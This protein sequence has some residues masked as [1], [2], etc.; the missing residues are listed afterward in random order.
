M[1]F[2]FFV[3]RVLGISYLKYKPKQLKYGFVLFWA[4]RQEQEAEKRASDA[5]IVEEKTKKRTFQYNKA[6]KII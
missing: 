3:E 5:L 6:Y 4:K 2:N 1:R